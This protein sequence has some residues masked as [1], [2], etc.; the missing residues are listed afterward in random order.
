MWRPYEVDPCL[1]RFNKLVYTTPESARSQ[2]RVGQRRPRAGGTQPERGR[3]RPTFGRLHPDI[4]I[5]PSAALPLPKNEGVALPCEP[6]SATRIPA[7]LRKNRCT[8][9]FVVGGGT[10]RGE[11]PTPLKGVLK[12]TILRCAVLRAQGKG[13]EGGAPR[14]ACVA[15]GHNG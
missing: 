4:L 8:T 3:T 14:C 11:E 12:Q 6:C 2:S 15:P 10:F 1:N 9:P 5:A 13:R 7:S